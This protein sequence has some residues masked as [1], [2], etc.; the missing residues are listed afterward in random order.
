MEMTVQADGA[1][2]GVIYFRPR[3]ENFSGNFSIEDGG[4]KAATSKGL[5]QTYWLYVVKLF[6]RCIDVVGRERIP[7]TGPLIV[8]ANHHNSVVDAMLI[9]PT[10]PRA[11]RVL[12]NAS[13]FRNPLVGPFLRL[14][15]AVPVNRRLETGDDPGKNDA[16][17]AAA[18]GALRAG[19]ALMIFPEGRTTPRPCSSVRCFG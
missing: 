11:V 19:G 8:A 18:I 4:I 3:P 10:F 5:H 2:S 17:F 7:T 15:G 9:V 16:L 14:M 6:Y 1:Y 12:A 13:L